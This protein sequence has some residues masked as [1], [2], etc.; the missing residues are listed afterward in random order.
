LRTK[1]LANS[2]TYA[3]AVSG[4]DDL[5]NA[6][7][8]SEIECGRPIPLVDFYEWYKSNGGPGGGGFCSFSPERRAPS[9]GAASIAL[10]LLAGLGWRRAQGRAR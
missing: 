7:V 2:T 9:A 6:G 4:Q 8:L 1:R 3:V 5:G 10:L